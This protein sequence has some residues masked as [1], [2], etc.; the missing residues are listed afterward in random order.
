MTKPDE[1]LGLDP[2]ILDGGVPIRNRGARVHRW[3]GLPGRPNHGD[4]PPFHLVLCR[5]IPRSRLNSTVI[6]ALCWYVGEDFESILQHHCFN[7]RFVCLKRVYGVCAGYQP[8]VTAFRHQHSRRL[9]RH[10]NRTNQ[11]RRSRFRNKQRGRPQLAAQPVHQ[12]GRR[13]RGHCYRPARLEHD[14]RPRMVKLGPSRAE[15]E[16]GGGA[17][18]TETKLRP[19][20]H[21]MM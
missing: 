17:I 15:H 14:E 21:P 5:T 3:A 8:Y 9:R 4:R 13:F 1:E 10:T 16:A 11:S 20:P 7:A 12:H 2:A 18:S 19:P 6:H